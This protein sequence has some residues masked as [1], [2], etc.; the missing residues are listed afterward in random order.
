MRRKNPVDPTCTVATGAV[1]PG[2]AMFGK[3]ISEYFG[4]L[5]SKYSRTLMARTLMA[6]LPWLFRTLS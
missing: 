4:K 2:S 5:R 1:Q 6:R 3:L